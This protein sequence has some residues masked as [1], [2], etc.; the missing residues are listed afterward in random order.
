M[1]L[2]GALNAATSSLS[3]QSKALANISD[4][5]ANSQTTAY[6]AG[7]T[8]FSSLVAG[9]G[10]SSSGGVTATN[11]SNNTV[12]GLLAESTNATDL[13]I[14]GDGYFIVT[15]D[16]Q[17]GQTYYTRNGEFDID[18]DGYLENNGYYLMGWP[19][20]NAGNVTGGA[21]E[22]ALAP[23]DLDSVQSSVEATTSIEIQANLPADAVG[24][25]TIETS[26]SITTALSS[27]IAADDGDTLS[28]DINGTSITATAGTSTT[29]AITVSDIAAA[30]NAETATTG[31]SASIDAGGSLILASNAAGATASITIDNV[32]VGG[33]NTGLTTA[34][35]ATIGIADAG[36]DGTE[37]V[38]GTTTNNDGSTFTTSL[39]VFD[40]LGT[41]ATVEARWTKTG[42]NSWEMV[43]SD[44]VLSSSG[45]AAGTT[46]STP[47]AITFN[48]DG[49]LASTNPSPPTFEI[50]N[51]TTGAADSEISLNLGTVGDD[52]GLTQ[53]A[54]DE[55]T[56]DINLKKVTQDGL[57]YGTLSAVEISDDGSVIAF[58]DNGEDR[59]IYKIPVATF[60]NPNGLS[61]S[62]GG[63]YSRSSTS[64]NSTLHEAGDDGAGSIKGFRLESSTTDTSEEFSSMLTAQQAY[65]ASSQ[66][67]STANSMFDK[68]LDAV[69]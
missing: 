63:I 2:M 8:S 46:S 26:P 40:S 35:L 25:E 18:S 22:N 59:V 65:S 27:D 47:I 53:H 7:N 69:R 57:A 64:G 1:S 37:T 58:F 66:I 55:T 60:G 45:G 14:E 17:N 68:L 11:R 41:G 10:S 52:N 23:I 34:N 54:S 15:D 49:S 31:V 62:S 32:S 3:A 9:S 13:A 51:W 4:N 36:A 30:I 16:N 50:S 24:P 28:F 48:E 61:E 43:L 38:T 67:M 5:L 44:P 12:G 42:E 20:D 29:G 19:T 33:T 39:E 6:K 56:P 21:S